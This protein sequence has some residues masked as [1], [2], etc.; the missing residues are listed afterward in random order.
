MAKGYPHIVALARVIADRRV[1]LGLSFTQ[2]GALA[3]VDGGQ[4]FRVCRGEFKTL[5]PSVL[6]I[7]N[8]LDIQP[9]GSQPLVQADISIEAMLAAEAIRAWDRT[10]SGAHLLTRVLRAIHP[11]EITSSSG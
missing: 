7:C 4:A 3:G 1:A 6:K 8:A 10:E 9:K 5:N 11:G 2:L